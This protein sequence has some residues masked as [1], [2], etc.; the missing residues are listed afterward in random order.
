MGKVTIEHISRLTGLSRGTIS[1]ALND[2]SDIN[3]KTK[4]RVLDACV[5]VNYVPS[6]AAR[7]LATGRN[8][9]IALFVDSFCSAFSASVLRGAASPAFDAD[10]VLHPLE[11]GSTAETAVSRLKRFAADRI[12]AIISAV[13][14]D[15]GAAQVLREMTGQHP[16]V[17]CWPVKG[18]ACDVLTPDH[19][20][21]GR[22]AARHVLGSGVSDVVYLH[23]DSD[24][25]GEERRAGFQEV[26]RERGL[27]ADAATHALVTGAGVGGVDWSSIRP[28]LERGAAVI[29]EDD[30]L[31]ASALVASAECGRLA[32]R[33]I[34]IMG[35]G[36][37]P[38]GERIRP[39]LSTVDLGGEEIGRR[40]VETVLARIAKKRMD[41]PQTVHIPPRLL[42]RES[43][44]SLN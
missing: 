16:V 10:Y 9:S 15:A 43:T 20:E 6:H 42:I 44:Q 36:N 39:S 35:L 5:E 30:F 24:R 22:M 17:S 29:A 26:C 40:A 8:Y 4:Q 23:A 38:F 41:R 1:R 14:L 3:Q 37:E 34:A 11:L 32:G 25:A 33:D 2:R 12:D 19:A 31:A 21:A 7:S 13:A 18:L 28:L 27:D